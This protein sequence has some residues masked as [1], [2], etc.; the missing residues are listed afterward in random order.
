M[1]TTFIGKIH[2]SPIDLMAYTVFVTFDKELKEIFYD[3]VVDAIYDEMEK[4][5]PEKYYPK[6][7][8]VDIFIETTE[9]DKCMYY[10]V[11]GDEKYVNDYNKLYSKVLVLPCY[12]YS[13][14]DEYKL[15]DIL[16]KHNIFNINQKFEYN[17]M[18]D[19]LN[20]IKKNLYHE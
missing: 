6:I 12:T 10:P 2:L 9:N 15:Y 7:K 13:L 5:Y 8:L 18:H 17:I 19:V 4:K 14:S 20:E 3:D 11:V 16:I 1:K